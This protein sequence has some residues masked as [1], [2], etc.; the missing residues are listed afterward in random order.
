[1]DRETTYTGF[2]GSVTV[3]TKEG[4]PRRWAVIRE[5]VT[6]KPF[7]CSTHNSQSQADLALKRVLRLNPNSTFWVGARQ[8]T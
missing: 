7:I 4:K 6:S 3:Q 5:D 1:M 8:D 2:G